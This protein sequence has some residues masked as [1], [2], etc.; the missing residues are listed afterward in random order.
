MGCGCKNKKKKAAALTSAGQP[1]TQ[2]DISNRKIE[3]QSESDYQSRVQEALKQLMEIKKRK[4]NLR[5]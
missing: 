2:A 4:Q 1:N 5:G 3:I